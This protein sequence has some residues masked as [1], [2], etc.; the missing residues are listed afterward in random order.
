MRLILPKASERCLRF[1]SLGTRKWDCF[2]VTWCLRFSLAGAVYGGWKL[3]ACLSLWWYAL[4]VPQSSAVG[5]A[6][7]PGA[8]GWVARHLRYEVHTF[9]WRRCWGH[10]G[11]WAE[12]GEGGLSLAMLLWYYRSPGD[13]ALLCRRQLASS[14]GLTFHLKAYQFCFQLHEVKFFICLG[15]VQHH[16]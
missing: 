9:I 12:V 13:L 15:H 3:Q 2:G 10:V 16:G 1:R 4:W 11:L 6:E 5:S 14:S 7:P 8:L